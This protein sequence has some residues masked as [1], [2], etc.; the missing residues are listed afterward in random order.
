MCNHMEPSRIKEEEG[1]FFSREPNTYVG[2]VKVIRHGYEDGEETRMSFL[3]GLLGDDRPLLLISV[4]YVNRASGQ[5]RW[6][7]SL[8]QPLTQYMPTVV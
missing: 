3:F 7:L 1:T 6:D 2:E 8:S 4:C 5:D